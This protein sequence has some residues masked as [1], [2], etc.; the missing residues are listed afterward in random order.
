MKITLWR[1]ARSSGKAAS[2]GLS[3]VTATQIMVDE[4]VTEN[5]SRLG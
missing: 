5:V 3:G 2:G 1:M 4:R